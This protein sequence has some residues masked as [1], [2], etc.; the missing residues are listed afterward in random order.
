MRVLDA[1]KACLRISSPEYS[2]Q[3]V[4]VKNRQI[5]LSG[6]LEQFHPILFR[7]HPPYSNCGHACF[8][9]RLN[10]VSD[11]VGETATRSEPEAKAPRESMWQYSQ[12]KR[13]SSGKGIRSPYTSTPSPLAVAISK[14]PVPS[15]PSVGS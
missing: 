3:L 15:P 5:K 8:Q 13:V 6:S 4:L 2:G 11:E 12:S 7:D 1:T 9:Q 14:I 10:R